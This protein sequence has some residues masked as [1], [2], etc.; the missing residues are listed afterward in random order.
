MGDRRTHDHVVALAGIFQAVTLVQQVAREGS[1]EA[2]AFE[3]TIA[4]LF[5][6][7]A[8]SSD[9]VFGG[10]AG[11]ECGLRTLCRQLGD[12]KSRR[13]PEL[14]RYAVRL[15]F[16]E[17][18]LSRDRRLMDVVRAGID[19]AAEQA[20]H[21]STTHENVLARLAEI[22]SSTVS[23]IPPRIMVQGQ[24]EHLG[25][26]ANANRIRALLL[27]GIR[28]AVLWR[29]LGGSRVRLLFSRR[30][31]VECAEALLAEPCA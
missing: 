12:D 14:M 29:Q 11:L 4:S 1:V 21:F 30:R 16:L 15:L 31:L 5:R 20:R 3:S 2:S 27:A 9:E 23:T 28:A 22:Y 17:R 26:P 10:S 19:A 6:I 25:N 13:D 8:A 24:P 7:D 18:K